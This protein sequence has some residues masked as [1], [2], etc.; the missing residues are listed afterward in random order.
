MLLKINTKSKLNES[1]LNSSTSRKNNNKVRFKDNDINNNNS[2]K[3]RNQLE[4]S[5]LDN[6]KHS[7]SSLDLKIEKIINNLD[8]EALKLE[9]VTML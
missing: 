4:D 6:N 1:S 8:R 9:H 2:F 3:D 5:N 7:K